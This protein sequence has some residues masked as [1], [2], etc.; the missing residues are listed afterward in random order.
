MSVTEK[1]SSIELSDDIS[2]RGKG[3]VVYDESERRYPEVSEDYDE[4]WLIAK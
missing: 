4:Y 1:S 3:Y 2:Y